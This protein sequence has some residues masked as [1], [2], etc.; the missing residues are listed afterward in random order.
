MKNNIENKNTETNFSMRVGCCSG[1]TVAKVTRRGHLKIFIDTGCHQ[2][3]EP[4]QT[5]R[6]V[7]HGIYMGR[8]PYG[9]HYMKSAADCLVQFATHMRGACEV[10]FLHGETWW[11]LKGKKGLEGKFLM[12]YWQHFAEVYREQQG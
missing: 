4:S 2:D 6:E 7:S 8:S 12:N 10:Q 1:W 11:L 3:Y 5:I 9:G